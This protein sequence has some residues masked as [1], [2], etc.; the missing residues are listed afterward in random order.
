MK[1]LR[2]T[3]PRLVKMIS[4][5]GTWYQQVK[6]DD[7]GYWAFESAVARDIKKGQTRYEPFQ[8]EL[9]AMNVFGHLDRDQMT[10][11]IPVQDRLPIRVPQI[12]VLYTLVF[13]LASLVR[14]DPHSVAH[15]QQS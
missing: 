4:D 13:W 15:L 1:Q 6:S 5:G 9:R 10:Y 8:R 14:Y 2:L 11:S 7:M 3:R 12:M